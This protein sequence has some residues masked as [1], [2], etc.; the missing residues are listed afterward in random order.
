MQR[1]YVHFTLQKAAI[2]MTEDAF[3]VEVQDNGLLV[4]LSAT[5]LREL[6]QQV[7]ANDLLRDATSSDHALIHLLS[8][9][10]NIHLNSHVT[11]KNG[12]NLI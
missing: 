8:G 6:Y 5:W 1:M 4:Y 7:L 11:K 9:N 3:V 12:E 10:L 2:P